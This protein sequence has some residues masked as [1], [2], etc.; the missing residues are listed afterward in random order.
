MLQVLF[1][2]A[3][4]AKKIK[5]LSVLITRKSENDNTEIFMM[6]QNYVKRL[7]VLM[8]PVCIH[9]AVDRIS[10]LRKKIKGYLV[11]KKKQK[12]I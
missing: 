3:N 6:L 9:I 7:R 8:Q 11:M 2:N 4:V 1:V 12:S 10:L 5:R